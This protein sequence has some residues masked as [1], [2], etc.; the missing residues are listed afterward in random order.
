MYK[1]VID[2]IIGYK[3]LINHPKS[4]VDKRPDDIPSEIWG[5][6]I[7]FQSLLDIIP[8]D[9]LCNK[10]NKSIKYELNVPI[11]IVYSGSTMIA[12]DIFRNEKDLEKCKPIDRWIIVHQLGRVASHSIL[13]S[14]THDGIIARRFMDTKR[15]VLTKYKS[16]IKYL[17]HSIIEVK[18]GNYKINDLT[19]DRINTTLNEDY[20]ISKYFNSG[21]DI[22]RCRYIHFNT[23]FS[24]LRKV[25]AKVLEITYTHKF[26]VS[27]IFGNQDGPI[28]ECFITVVEKIQYKIDN[29]TL[30]IISTTIK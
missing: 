9:E 27:N 19:I 30:R 16:I 22:S 8:K 17:T 11:R 20:V 10:L 29:N 7:T 15:E 18:P 26:D 13:H 21:V 4:R 25:S 28:S 3:N 23:S 12:I 24:N 1:D 5:N 14:L 2:I 6:S